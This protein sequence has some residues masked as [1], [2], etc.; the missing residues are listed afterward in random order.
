MALRFKCEYCGSEIIT[1]WLKVGER[2]ECKM[3]HKKNIIPNH[4]TEIEDPFKTKAK[5][6]ADLARRLKGREGDAIDTAKA[7]KKPVVKKKRNKK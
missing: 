7:V 5:E 2:A 1:Q 3:C 6:L 4:A